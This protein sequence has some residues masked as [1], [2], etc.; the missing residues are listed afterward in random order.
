MSLS[1]ADYAISIMSGNFLQRGSIALWNKYTRAAMAVKDGFDLVLELPFV[2]ATG[3]ARDFADG[4][5]S[6]LKHLNGVDYLAFGVETANPKLF[7]QVSDIL[8]TEPS[9]YKA[10]FKQALSNG[11]SYPKACQMALKLTC[12]EAA[13]ALFDTPNNTLALSYLCAIRKM[14]AD[15]TPIFIPRIS[16]GYHD[17]T[18]QRSISSATAIRTALQNGGD[19]QQLSAQVPA[20]TL[21]D[22]SL[23]ASTY[24]SDEH[25]TP[26]LQT[27][28]L[29]K[30]EL[31]TI[32]DMT[33]ALA[34]KL[35]AISCANSYHTILDMLKSKD[36]TRSRI[37][38]TILH[39]IVQYTKSM[40]SR[41]MMQD[42]SF[43]ANILSFRRDSSTCIRT[44][45][46]NTSIP[47]ITKKADFLTQLAQFPDI[48]KSLAQAMWDYDIKATNLYNCIYQNHYGTSLPN[49]F[50]IKLPVL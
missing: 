34:D 37:A 19:I 20:T 10:T 2:Y 28:L 1:R 21:Q 30:Q 11:Y 33:P 3:S 18:L 35:Y 38:R 15:I 29:Q 46:A 14:H 44:L 49:D 40:R 32:C 13:A 17:T 47:L 48:D 23:P 45:H 27:C 39:T 7:E 6:I 36:I 4:A 12:G 9:D 43:Y 42:Y 16:S 26:F 50:T 8:I 5:I 31:S 25:L 22:L 24:L 41:F